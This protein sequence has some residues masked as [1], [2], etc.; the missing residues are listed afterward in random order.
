M[1]RLFIAYERHPEDGAGPE[2]V[3]TVMS[4]KTVPA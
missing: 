1:I 3:G 4:P 2:R